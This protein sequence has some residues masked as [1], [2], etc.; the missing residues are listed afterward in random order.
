MRRV[1]KENSLG[2]YKT[3]YINHKN[4]FIPVNV[5]HKVNLYLDMHIVSWSD[6]S[7]HG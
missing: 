1:Y 4:I 6:I 2:N 7:K 5:K 3:F